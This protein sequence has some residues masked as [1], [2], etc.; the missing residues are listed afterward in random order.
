MRKTFFIA[1][2]DHDEKVE[3]EKFN[4]AD[5]SFLASFNSR[6]SLPDYLQHLAYL[7]PLPTCSPQF[8]LLGLKQGEIY[9]CE[10]DFGIWAGVGPTKELALLALAIAGKKNHKEFSDLLR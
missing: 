1:Y 7:L 3:L 9:W 5:L 8:A 2:Y 4:S 6:S 10:S